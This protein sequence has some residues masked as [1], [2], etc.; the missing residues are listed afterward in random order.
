MTL[1]IALVFALAAL[2]A[3]EV[4]FVPVPR[5]PTTDAQ[6]AEYRALVGMPVAAFASQRV[7]ADTI[8][9]F[10]ATP[11]PWRDNAVIWMPER[12]EFSYLVC[13]EGE[14]TL[15]VRSRQSDGG[16]VITDAEGITAL[17]G[18][19]DGRTIAFYNRR[20]LQSGGREFARIPRPVKVTLPREEAG[21]LNIMNPAAPIDVQWPVAQPLGNA[22][23]FHPDSGAVE[24]FSS[25]DYERDF[26]IVSGKLS[27]QELI[28]AVMAILGRNMPADQKARAIRLVAQ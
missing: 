16:V 6:L 13:C 3:A 12:T 11:K 24:V 21:R 4:K 14:F 28:E 25:S 2:A 22:L 9:A 17:E 10:G 20:F 27:D 18:I 5:Y 7:V 26:P 8:P 1:R 23:R 15:K 19:F